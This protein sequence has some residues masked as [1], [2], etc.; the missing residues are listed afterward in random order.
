MCCMYVYRPHSEFVY[1]SMRQHQTP[2]DH[3]EFLSGK[4]EA[5]AA[6]N[7]VL[8]DELQGKIAELLSVLGV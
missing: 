7:I 6:M 3:P 4:Y 2:K 1:P 8:K 5:V